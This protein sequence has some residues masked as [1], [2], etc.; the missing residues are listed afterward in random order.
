MDLTAHG[1]VLIYTENVDIDG[2]PRQPPERNCKWISLI[3]TKLNVAAV[4]WESG[5]SNGLDQIK[6]DQ[7]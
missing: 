6:K 1:T 5:H 2:R 3:E 4:T 7:K